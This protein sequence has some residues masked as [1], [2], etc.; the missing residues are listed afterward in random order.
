M[1]SQVVPGGLGWIDHLHVAPEFRGRGV[2]FA[3]FRHALESLASEGFSE[4][5]LW[6]YEA[7]VIARSFYDR[8][9]WALDGTTA[10]KRLTWVGR[11]GVP[12]EATL[13]MVRYRGS[14]ELPA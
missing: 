2:G 6:V 9:G 11:D 7:N 3:L 5:V 14:T 8:T 10:D 13:T 1:P 4:A 12:G